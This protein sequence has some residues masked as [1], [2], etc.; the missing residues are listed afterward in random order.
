MHVGKKHCGPDA[1]KVH[2]NIKLRLKMLVNI[3]GYNKIIISFILYLDK[4]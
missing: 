3:I 2:G 1:A 4:G